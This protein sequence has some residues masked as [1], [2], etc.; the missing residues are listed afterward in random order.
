MTATGSMP[1]RNLA[2]ASD[3]E[4]Q[5]IAA[6]IMTIAEAGVRRRAG[7]VASTL[8]GREDGACEAFGYHSVYGHRPCMA[9]ARRAFATARGRR[10]VVARDRG[11]LSRADRELGRQAPCLRR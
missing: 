3:V 6:T 7:S 2:S 11:R 5:A 8:T 10:D 1:V 9:L 4:K